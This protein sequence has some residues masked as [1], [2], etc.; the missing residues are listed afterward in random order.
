MI[1]KSEDQQNQESTD[2]RDT[3]SEKDATQGRHY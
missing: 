2:V 1:V 3:K